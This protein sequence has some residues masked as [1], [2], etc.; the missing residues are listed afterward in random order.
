MHIDATRIK[1]ASAADLE[2]HIAGVEAIKRRGGSHD[3][4]WK[5]ASDLSG[6]SEVKTGGRWPK[7]VLLQ[8]DARCKRVGETAEMANP[9][10]DTP[11]RDTAPSSFTGKEVSNVRH[12]VTT[13]QFERGR[14]CTGFTVPVYECVEGC[15]VKVLAAASPGVV[16]RKPE[17]VVRKGNGSK[18][19]LSRGGFAADK[20]IAIPY[21]DSGTATR[22]FQQLHR[23]EF[24]D[25]FRYQPKPV[26]SEKDAGLD[27]FAERK[28][29]KNV[30]PT[31]KPVELIR[32][33][34]RLVAAP[35]Q[36]VFNPF[37]GGGSEGVAAVLEGCRWIGCELNDTEAEPFVSIA[38]ARLTHHVGGSYVPRES[39]R[40]DEIDGQ[41]TLF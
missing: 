18:P 31:S 29:A 15:P 1:H 5:N 26:R 28:G 25:V 33:L 8:H 10:W 27:H 34:T 40:A 13:F 24:D 23:S 20:E 38:R 9:T 32:W 41:E 39:L 7:N 21:S 4:S 12:G 22:Y 16:V 37:C 2:Q 17:V 11:A 35:G 36:V 3:D 14:E 19:E 6:A 30:H